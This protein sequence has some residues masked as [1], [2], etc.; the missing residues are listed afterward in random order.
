MKTDE[1]SW[2]GVDVNIAVDLLVATYENLSDRLILV[3]SDTDLLPAIAEQKKEQIV[4]YVGFYKPSV[5]L[6]ATCLASRLLT[7]EDWKFSVKKKKR[8]KKKRPVN[9]TVSERF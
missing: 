3:S 7:K 2:K 5:A 6:V 4:E 8:G 1:I 9:L